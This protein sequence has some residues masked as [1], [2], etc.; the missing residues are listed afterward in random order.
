[1]ADKKDFEHGA[2]ITAVIVI[3]AIILWWL[4]HQATITA[5]PAVG[6]NTI[7]PSG[8]PSF[9]VHGGPNT[10][11]P[12]NFPSSTINLGSP[13]SLGTL[14]SGNCSCGCSGSG[15]ST[16][17]FTLPDFSAQTLAA[18]QQLQNSTQLALAGVYQQLGYSGAVF[19]ANNIPSGLGNN[20]YL[21]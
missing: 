8:S 21:D 18:E 14:N 6:A 3:V 10:Y 11:G 9:I 4:M 17:N 2:I 5:A 12:V 7:V 13:T 20:K 19:V 15:G 16:I 1:V